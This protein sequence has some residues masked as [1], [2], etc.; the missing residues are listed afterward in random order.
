LMIE[1]VSFFLLGDPTALG[2]KA[3]RTPPPTVSR[4]YSATLS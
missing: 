1:L 2:V 4:R 3:A